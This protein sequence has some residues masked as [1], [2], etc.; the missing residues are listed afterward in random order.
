MRY[1]ISSLEKLTAIAF[2][3]ILVSSFS[4]SAQAIS[5]DFTGTFTE[6]TH[7]ITNYHNPG[8]EYEALPINTGDTFYG[9]ISYDIPPGLTYD[10]ISYSQESSNYQNFSENIFNYEIHA[11]D[12]SVIGVGA[13]VSL[14]ITHH[15]FS[16]LDE[17][18]MASY[19]AHDIGVADSMVIRFENSS[20]IVFENANLPQTL[21]MSAFD[22]FFFGFQPYMDDNYS[23]SFEATIDTFNATQPVPEPA[24]ILLIGT[25]L[26][27]LI[28]A[29]VRR[30]KHLR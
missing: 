4:G 27:G 26:A 16:L 25:G 20:N 21:N 14:S 9:N 29:N 30:K 12:F 18:P 22:S 5:Y 17:G 19:Q 3:V 23:A 7:H 8:M 1:S 11:G 28:G 15:S 6:V 2:V 13:M 10:E 24:S